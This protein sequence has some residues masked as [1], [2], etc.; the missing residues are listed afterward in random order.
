MLRE[1]DQVYTSNS[2]ERLTSDWN[3]IDDSDVVE[4]MGR[5][6]LDS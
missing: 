3:T 2:V 4:L 6:R 5:F 1:S